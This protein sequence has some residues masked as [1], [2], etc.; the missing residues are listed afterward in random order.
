MTDNDDE[1]DDEENDEILPDD[2]A[3]IEHKVDDFVAD[4]KQVQSVTGSTGSTIDPV[5]SIRF[6]HVGC[7]HVITNQTFT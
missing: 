5:V 2:E 7:Y 6:V 1:M 3:D 4:E